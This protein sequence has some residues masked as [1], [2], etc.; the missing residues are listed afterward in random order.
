MHIHRQIQSFSINIALIMFEMGNWRK[1]CRCSAPSVCWS[2]FFF[3]DCF[4]ATQV[5]HMPGLWNMH[6]LWNKLLATSCEASLPF[7]SSVDCNI[8]SSGRKWD[9][10]LDLNLFTPTGH[11]DFSL[12]GPC[13]N[14]DSYWSFPCIFPQ[15]LVDLASALY[16]LRWCTCS[17]FLVLMARTWYLK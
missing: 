16:P 6:R 14:S 8:N 2:F 10:Q 4:C 7:P 11:V 12:I 9:W 13:L 17:G 5:I 15:K 3:H 1:N